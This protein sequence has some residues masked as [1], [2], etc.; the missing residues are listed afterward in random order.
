MDT[1]YFFADVELAMN[2][3]LNLSEETSRHI[4]QVLRMKVGDQFQLTNGK[5]EVCSAEILEA[6]KKVCRVRINQY[7]VIPK[8]RKET[9]IAISL[10]KNAGRWEWFLEKAAELGIDKIIPII[11]ERTERQ[12]FRKDRMNSILISA[13][14]QSKQCWITTLDDPISMNLFLQQYVGYNHVFIAHCETGN[15][16]E[17]SSRLNQTM[18]HAIVLVGPEGDFTHDE[19]EKSILEGFVEV[20]IGSTRLRTETAGVTAA[21]LLKQLVG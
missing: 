6:T 18:D 19:V 8:T 15:K 10:L 14:L 9:I 17:L 13:M 3:E 4:V 11:C 7:Q 12:F 5:G 2:A 21:V 1:P 20:S 16:V